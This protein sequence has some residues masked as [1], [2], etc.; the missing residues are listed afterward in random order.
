[1][2]QVIKIKYQDELRRLRINRDDT[3]AKLRAKIEELMNLKSS[4]IQ[5]K[6]TDSEGDD[7]IIATDE[8]LREALEFH[9]Q[10]NT[11]LRINLKVTPIINTSTSTSTSTNTSTV[12][13]PTVPFTNNPIPSTSAS[14]A[15]TSSDTPMVDNVEEKEEENA[16]HGRWKER[17]GHHW[18]HHQPQQPQLPEVDEYGRVLHRHV[19]CDGCQGHIYG[20]RY[21]CSDCDDFDLCETC[22]AQNLHPEDHIL[23]KIKLPSRIHVYK[24]YVIQKFP[25]F[26]AVGGGVCPRRRWRGCGNVS[27]AKCPQPQTPQTQTPQTQTQ[28]PQPEVE[29]RS[30]TPVEQPVQ[31][32][33]QPAEQTQPSTGNL[34]RE[35]FQYLLQRLK[36]MGFDDEQIN[37]KLLRETRGDIELIIQR[38]TEM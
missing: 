4:V 1:M 32:T 36:D 28:T 37:R 21:K 2:E 15:S 24:P 19:I 14:A 13:T 9:N 5:M 25:A 16:C 34:E 38:L 7:I 29:T 26:N 23:M 33:T 20:I 10:T 8:D 22:E 30:T 6:W 18:R 17:R 11:P 3:V 12:T 31:P 35:E 27:E